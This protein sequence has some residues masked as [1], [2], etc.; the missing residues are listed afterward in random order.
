LVELNQHEAV[1]LGEPRGVRFTNRG[2]EFLARDLEGQWRPVTESDLLLERQLP[3]AIELRL[4]IEG[5][6]V[7]LDSTSDFTSHRPQVLLEASGEA[8][9]FAA[10]LETRESE[11]YTVTGDG[12]GNL[13][14]GPEP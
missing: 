3:D 4:E 8:T 6:P 13:R 1:L 10:R 14:I 5:A 11:G 7:A 12:L 9:D 2:Y